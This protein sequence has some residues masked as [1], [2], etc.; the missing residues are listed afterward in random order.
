MKKL[1]LPGLV[2]ALCAPP[3]AIAD[4]T[5]DWFAS[6]TS[7]GASSY[8]NQQRGFYSAGSYSAR[9]NASTDPL[10]TI[11]PPR[12]SAGCGGVDVFL[13]GMTMLDPD[14]L[15]DK[16]QNMIAAAPAIAFDTAMKVMS[17]ELSETMKSFEKIIN[18]LNG[19]QIN[20]CQ[21]AKKLG[22]PVGDFIGNAASNRLRTLDAKVGTALGSVT[23]WYETTENQTASNQ[24][25]TED[26]KQLTAD[27]PTQF[28]NI[29]TT[30]SLL[31]NAADEFGF[32]YVDTMRGFVGDVMINATAAVKAPVIEP[33]SSC[34][35]NDES[36]VD[37]FVIGNAEKKVQTA[38]GPVCEKDSATPG[39]LLALV[40]NQMNAIATKIET[41]T[42]L[43]PAEQAF[44][45]SSP[46]PI[47][48][49]IVDSIALGDKA[50]AIALTEE[51]VAYAYAFYMVDD[52]YNTI[53][54]LMREIDAVMNNTGATGPQ[55][56]RTVYAEVS[57]H[58]TGIKKDAYQFRM[59]ARNSYLKKTE[60]QMAHIAFTA[61]QAKRQEEVLRRNAEDI[62]Q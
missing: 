62:T 52:L 24:E 23:S 16:L 42:A 33:I 9:F 1:I 28:K 12:V 22:E 21:F 35:N 38:G 39:G 41:K 30:G 37:D 34:P 47:L 44:L 57:D 51:V 8:K 49:I 36:S 17:K 11:S 60:E 25:P 4:W 10:L 3:T 32:A 29:F 7:S 54:N 45:T 50:M 19:I 5:D 27:C 53:D 14:Y 59:A 18:D 61:A 48:P 20:D 43:T 15:V 46:I 58:L 6:S 31:Q 26:I 55:C 13:G 2:L 40:S 56:D